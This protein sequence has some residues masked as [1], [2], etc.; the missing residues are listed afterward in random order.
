[1]ASFCHFIFFFSSRSSGER[2]LTKHPDTFLYS[3]DE[4]FTLAKRFN[5]RNFGSE[6][7]QRATVGRTT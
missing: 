2:W 3:L 4:A 5:V 1:M 7:A 6:L